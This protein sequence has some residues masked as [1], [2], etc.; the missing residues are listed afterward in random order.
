MNENN[1]VCWTYV[2][3]TCGGNN[4]SLDPSAAFH[5][6]PSDPGRRP[7]WFSV[8]GMDARQRRSQ[9]RACSR[10]FPNSNAKREPTARSGLLQVRGSKHHRNHSCTR[11]K[12]FFPKNSRGFSDGLSH[13][14]HL[15]K[16]RGNK[17]KCH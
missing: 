10:H 7:R 9:S 13:S 5:R 15:T 16:N 1:T 14:M 12:T 17:R 11:G 8:S 3:V 6:F 2:P 4:P